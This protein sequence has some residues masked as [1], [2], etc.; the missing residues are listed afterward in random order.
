MHPAPRRAAAPA[1]PTVRGRRPSPADGRQRLS[2]TARREQLI[3]TAL[4]LFA[5]H[6]FSGT[7]TRRIAAEAGV[8]EAVI[9]QHFSDKDALYAAILESRA[10]DPWSEQWFAELEL[11]AGGQDAARVL[12][13]LFEGIVDLHERDP[14]HLRLVIYSALE[15]HPLARR[16]QPRTAQ[17]YQVL[18]RFILNGQRA[19][20]FRAGPVAVLVRAVLALPIYHVFQ[21]RLFKTP[22]P[23]VQR[24]EL[25]ATGVQFALAGL[26]RPGGEAGS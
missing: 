23:A 13:C 2:M 24:D 16:L 12:T 8:T 26:A 6:G 14:H 25:I 20:R 5:E 9:F 15:Q 11:L 18:E 3:N 7:T 1:G 10:T 19:G 21:R 4:R 17:L 22:W